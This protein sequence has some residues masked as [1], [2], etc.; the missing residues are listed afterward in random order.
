MTKQRVIHIIIEAGVCILLL[1][2]I[3][4]YMT[5]TKG[6][7]F[8]GAQVVR[9]EAYED[10]Q[11]VAETEDRGKIDQVLWVYLHLDPRFDMTCVSRAGG[12]TDPFEEAYIIMYLDRPTSKFVKDSSWQKEL[13]CDLFQKI[14][15]TKE[16][17]YSSPGGC[18]PVVKESQQYFQNAMDIL[19]EN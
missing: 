19:K 9:I 4:L 12:D 1:G 11:L 5:L 10:H 2:G 14:Y 16:G 7:D 8:G 17:I 6:F 3:F 18:Y 15:L 13:G